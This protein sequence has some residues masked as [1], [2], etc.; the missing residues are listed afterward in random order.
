MNDEYIRGYKAGYTA[1]LHV[2]RCEIRGGPE[3]LYDFMVRRCQ[4]RGG[5]MFEGARPAFERGEYRDPEI[6]ELLRRGW[7]KPHQDPDKGWVPVP[8]PMIRPKEN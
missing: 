8:I 1:G 6:A 7:I 2:S 3:N 5:Y 4:S